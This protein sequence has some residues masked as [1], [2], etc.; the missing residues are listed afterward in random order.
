M[1]NTSE[2]LLHKT[3]LFVSDDICIAITLTMWCKPFGKSITRNLGQS[4]KV[5]CMILTLLHEIA[6]KTWKRE[7][8]RQGRF[9]RQFCGSRA[10]IQHIKTFSSQVNEKM[11][12][13]TTAFILGQCHR[14]TTI[15]CWKTKRQ[16][17][18]KNKFSIYLLY[19]VRFHEG[20]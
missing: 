12:D 6:N 14:A 20:L 3:F 16:N 1:Y 7:C 18:S 17:H 19:Y 8:S 13:K 10:R 9:R 5:L 11:E 4:L 2:I 15:S